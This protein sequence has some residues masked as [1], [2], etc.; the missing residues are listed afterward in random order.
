MSNSGHGKKEF[1][2]LLNLRLW[3]A[4]SYFNVPDLSSVGG[5][6]VLSRL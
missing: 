5:Q 2:W 4:G 1:V 3:K 6:H